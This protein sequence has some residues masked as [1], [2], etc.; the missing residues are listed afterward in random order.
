MG[1]LSKTLKYAAAGKVF[2]NVKKIKIPGK[3]AIFIV[4]GI[5]SFIGILILIAI[6][7]LII[8]I[9]GLITPNTI[10]ETTNSVQEVSRSVVQTVNPEQFIDANG[11]V[12]V[13]VIEEQIRS[14]P[15]AQLTQWADSFRDQVNQLL[16]QGEIV[17]SQA[18]QL[19]NLLP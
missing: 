4:A 8:W 6:I 15:P 12:E 3:K 2:G 19:L 10:T 7:A 17:Q 9:V 16:R 18:D 11:Q 14:L 1:K 13:Q 5:V